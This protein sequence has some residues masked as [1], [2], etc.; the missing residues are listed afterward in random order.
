VVNAHRVSEYEIRRLSYIK[1]MFRMGVRHLENA[2][3]PDIALAT[4]IF[5][6]CIEMM[7]WLLIQQFGIK[8]SGD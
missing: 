6:S 1:G 4:L 8:L 7:L 5:D 3:E 2:S